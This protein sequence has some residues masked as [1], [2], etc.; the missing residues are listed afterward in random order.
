[1]DKSTDWGRTHYVNKLNY[2][3]YI[4]GMI[5]KEHGLDFGPKEMDKPTDA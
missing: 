3:D 2:E 1:M 5:D 4:E